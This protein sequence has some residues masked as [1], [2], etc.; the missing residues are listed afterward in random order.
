[1]INPSILTDNELFVRYAKNDLIKWKQL[2]GI[3]VGNFNLGSGYITN[4]ELILEDIS[5]VASFSI[6][7]VETEVKYAIS[8]FQNNLIIISFNEA[9]TAIEKIRGCYEQEYQEYL[10]IKTA[11]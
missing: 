1:M 11:R 5:V 9:K 3:E 7:E 6:N 2:T 8:D 10:K 4:V